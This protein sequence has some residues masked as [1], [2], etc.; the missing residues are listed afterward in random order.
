VTLLPP[1]VLAEEMK[2]DFSEQKCIKADELYLRYKEWCREESIS[3]LAKQ[4]FG[5]Q[6]VRQFGD[7]K[8][9]RGPRGDRYFVYRLL[10]LNESF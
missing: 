4:N 1:D 9:R 10:T 7:L 6:I 2:K 8:H 5:K 3:P